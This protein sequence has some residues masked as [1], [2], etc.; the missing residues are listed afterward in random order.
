M[1]RPSSDIAFTP[2]VKSIQTRKGSRGAYAELERSGG[3][4]TGVSP[5][6]AAFICE[7]RSLFIATVNAQGQPYIQHRG[8][9]PGFLKILDETTLAMADFRGNRQ[10]ITHGNLEDNS[11]AFLFLIDYERRR[12]VKIWGEAR[13]VEND[14]ALIAAVTLPNYRARLEQ[15]IVFHIHAWDANCPS[16]IPQRFEIERVQKLLAEKDRVIEAHEK[17]IA[18]LSRRLGE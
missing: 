16:H 4:E 14:A 6:L 18:E 13:I 15:V 5:A 17:R 9:P 2:T 11:K 10:Y 1:D 3:W 8:G 12:R 7:Q